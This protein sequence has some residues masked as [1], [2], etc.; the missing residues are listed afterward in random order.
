CPSPTATSFPYTTLFRSPIDLSVD[1]SPWEFPKLCPLSFR[2]RVPKSG[3]ESPPAHFRI[4]RTVRLA[5]YFP[6]RR[7]YSSPARKFRP[8]A[9]SEEH[10]SELQSPDHLVC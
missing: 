10:T 5:R 4:V 1:A 3:R 2:E 6:R 9:R 8:F 7:V